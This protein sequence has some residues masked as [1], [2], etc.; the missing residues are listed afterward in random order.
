MIEARLSCWVRTITS[1]DTF[2]EIKQTAPGHWSGAGALGSG[3]ALETLPG[4]GYITCYGEIEGLS[5]YHQGV[6]SGH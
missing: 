6:P 4:V 1:R 5:L 2:P 3:Y